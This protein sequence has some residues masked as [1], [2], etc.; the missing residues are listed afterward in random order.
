MGKEI[1]T[2]EMWLKEFEKEL[3]DLNQ[4]EELIQ[5]EVEICRQR[6]VPKFGVLPPRDWAE[7]ITM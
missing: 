1:T 5:Q 6:G 4:P 3:R 2:K 7:M